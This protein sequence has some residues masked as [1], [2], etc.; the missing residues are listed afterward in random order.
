ML[1]VRNLNKI[2]KPKKGAS[3]TA[4]R[5]INLDIADKGLVFLLGKSGSGKST[6]LNIL[7][8]L[9]MYS[10][11]E[12]IIKGRSSSSFSKS[13]FDSYRNTFLGFVFQEFNI[14]DD[15]SV[16]K[17]IGLALELQKKKADKEA[18]EN[19]LKAVDLEDFYMRRPNELS[20]GQLQ[21]VS[22]ARALVKN[23]DII[24]ADEPTGSLDTNTGRQ[25]FDV[26]QKLAQDKLIIVVSHDRENAEVYADRIIE[27]KDGD[28]IHD[29]TRKAA[30]QARRYIA[31]K[32]YR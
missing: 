27:L 28:I 10:S 14:L 20:G 15:Y 11:G 30:M 23:P 13:D 5:D 4:L 7:G 19:I 16:G 17:N 18:I 32:L 21:R 29:R 25:V 22:I 1:Q 31:D 26:L 2:Y 9:D 12:I 8:G 3:V 6:L 24:L